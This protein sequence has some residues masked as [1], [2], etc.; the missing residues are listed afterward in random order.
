MTKRLQFRTD[1]TFRILQLADIQEGM[2]IRQ[3]TLRFMAAMLDETQPDLVVLT[4]DQVKGYSPTLRHSG[5]E[6]VKTVIHS[7]LKPIRERKIN[8]ALTFG[9]HDNESGVS[10]QTQME[11]YQSIPG[12]VHLDN[13]T[14]PGT[15][16]LPIYGHD[17]NEIALVLYFL[18]TGGILP[19]H[20][21]DTLKPEQV[22]W[23]TQSRR[24]LKV[25]EHQAVPGIIFQHI[26]IPEYFDLLL[27][28]RHRSAHSIAKTG[29]GLNKGHYTLN[30]EVCRPD[31]IFKEIISSP[32][33]NS[34]LFESLRHHDDIFALYCGHDHKNGFIG[35]LDGIDLGYTPCCGFGAYGP[36]TQRAG[37]QFD[38]TQADPK[39]YSTHLITYRDLLGEKTT[40]PFIDWLTQY[41]PTDFDM[42]K[43]WILRLLVLLALIL[44]IIWLLSL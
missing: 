18:D 34:G 27:K 6:G 28:S 2:D 10:N 39:A 7:I 26:P 20:Q 19:N 29:Y 25:L 42:I 4:S 41:I 44:G 43:T 36:G 1:G 31:G 12:C 24:A 21:Y 8:F 33:V 32:P 35:R 40:K 30:P 17:Q 22:Q 9:N 37:R 15:Y 5:V 3:D 11:I 38:F 16:Y 14:D 13:G 23:L